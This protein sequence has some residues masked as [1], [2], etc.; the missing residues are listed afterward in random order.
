[1]LYDF[2]IARVDEQH[3]AD[4]NQVEAVR[5]N[6]Q[7]NCGSEFRAFLVLLRQDYVVCEAQDVAQVE[8]DEYDD[9]HAPLLAERAYVIGH[10]FLLRKVFQ[11]DE[12]RSCQQTESGD[13][14]RWCVIR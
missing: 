9:Q 3:A 12:Y 13:L 7:T 2:E 4:R 1:M 14:D 11:Y 10:G 6:D 8:D 5:P